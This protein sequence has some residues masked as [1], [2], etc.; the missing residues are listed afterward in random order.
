MECKILERYKIST[1]VG[2]GSESGVYGPIGN[3]TD[4]TNVAGN[5]AILS[6]ID[7]DWGR[8]NLRS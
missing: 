6:I 4:W 2:G 3:A 5:I 7:G 8:A 1:S